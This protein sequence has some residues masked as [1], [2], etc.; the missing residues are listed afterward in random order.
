VA[1]WR[2]V[3]SVV[4]NVEEPNVFVKTVKA[5]IAAQAEES[6]R[7]ELPGEPI[8]NDEEED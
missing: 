8:A 4:T 1:S 7:T 2:N 5:A 6:W 3:E